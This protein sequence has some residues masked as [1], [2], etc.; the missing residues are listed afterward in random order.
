MNLKF[1]PPS[2]SATRY[3]V[4]KNFLAELK[5]KRAKR[6]VY[7]KLQRESAAF[8]FIGRYFKKKKYLSQ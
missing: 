3:S 2:R 1:R 7:K 4:G 6:R 8:V 5:I